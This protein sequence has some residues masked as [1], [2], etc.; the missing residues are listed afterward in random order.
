M[1][2]PSPLAERVESSEATQFTDCFV[3]T[4]ALCFDEKDGWQKAL[5]W[6]HVG[7]TTLHTQPPWALVSKTNV[8]PSTNSFQ[9]LNI[10]GGWVFCFS[11]CSAKDLESV[12]LMKMFPDLFG[13]VYKFAKKMEWNSRS[14]L[15]KMFHREDVRYWFWHLED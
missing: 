12:D 7:V 15:K 6:E 1:G 5:P 2:V 10:E 14:S 9:S 11:F 8:F 3:F 13:C 4:A